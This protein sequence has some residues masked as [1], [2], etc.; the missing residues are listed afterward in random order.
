MGIGCGSY[1]DIDKRDEV[2]ADVSDGAVYLI[3]LRWDT[4]YFTS[5]GS[6]TSFKRSGCVAS[7]V[8]GLVMAGWYGRKRERFLR[9]L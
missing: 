9:L 3:D 4:T 7:A 1:E 8:E 2:V 6:M 5:R